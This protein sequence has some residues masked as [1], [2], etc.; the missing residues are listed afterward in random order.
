MLLSAD[1]FSSDN[2]NYLKHVTGE[3]VLATIHNSRGW[4]A[5][6]LDK[7]GYPIYSTHGRARTVVGALR[8]MLMHTSKKIDG[9]AFVDLLADGDVHETTTSTGIDFKVSFTCIKA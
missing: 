1:T 8:M 2:L 5:V 9:A 7:S 6:V 4:T 3:V